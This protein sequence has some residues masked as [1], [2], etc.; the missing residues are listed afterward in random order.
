MKGLRII[1]NRKKTKGLA[2]I[3]LPVNF[4][5][6]E[7]R[8]IYPQPVQWKE[9]KK[10]CKAFHTWCC[11]LQLNPAKKFD[12]K[13]LAVRIRGLNG[14]LCEGLFFYSLFSQPPAE[15]GT[16]GFAED[17]E[18]GEAVI[19]PERV[20]LKKG[21]DVQG[22]PGGKEDGGGEEELP[23]AGQVIFEKQAHI[24]LKVSAFM[25]ILSLTVVIY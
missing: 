12:F 14:G 22:R 20:Q 8:S 1:D 25:I 6:L 2:G 11:I 23:S 17:G 18:G 24:R 16:A 21:G 19:F 9:R 3:F 7:I 10:G 15:T 5:S 13:R 4:F